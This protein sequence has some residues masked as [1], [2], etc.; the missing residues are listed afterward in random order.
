MHS[1]QCLLY[2]QYVLRYVVMT[3]LKRYSK[4]LSSRYALLAILYLH[5]HLLS[6]FVTYY[7]PLSSYGIL[8]CLLAL[9]SSY[10]AFYVLYYLFLF[11]ILYFSYVSYFLSFLS[12]YLLL[13]SFTCSSYYFTRLSFLRIL[14]VFLVSNPFL[15]LPI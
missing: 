1:K 13:L 8:F 10:I 15:C 11:R 2:D 4:Y 5:F 14:Q 12:P 7:L 9:L 3:S 6:I